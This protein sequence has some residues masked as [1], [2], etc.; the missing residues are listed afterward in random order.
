MVTVDAEAATRQVDKGPAADSSDPA[1]CEEFRRF[2]GEKAELRRFRDAT[3]C[4]STIWQTP[5]NLR[6]LIMPQMARYALARHLPPPRLVLLLLAMQTITHRVSVK[7]PL[8]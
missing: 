5:P 8:A 2:W 4:E 7:T 1:E 3:L 6:H